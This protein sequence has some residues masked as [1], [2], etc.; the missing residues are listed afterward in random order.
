MLPKTIYGLAT[1]SSPGLMSAEDKAKLDSNVVTTS[2]VGANNGIAQLDSS[3][4]VP[5]S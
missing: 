5:A 3:G 2:L 1:T 4:K